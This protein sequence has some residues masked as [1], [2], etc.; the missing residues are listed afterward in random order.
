MYIH[1]DLIAENSNQIA[2]FRKE[3]RALQDQV[4]GLQKQVDVLQHTVAEIQQEPDTA[5]QLVEREK[6]LKDYKAI[7]F[8]LAEQ[9]LTTLRRQASAALSPNGKQYL[10]HDVFGP[11][12]LRELDRPEHPE[13]WTHSTPSAFSDPSSSSAE[14]GAKDRADRILLH[15]IAFMSKQGDRQWVTPPLSIPNIDVALS[16]GKVYAIL[17]HRLH[18]EMSKSKCATRDIHHQ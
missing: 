4:H 9:V 2:Q 11:E 1:T 12:L 7:S 5:Q 6:Q 14:H 17:L 13:I 18:E 3:K 10:S 16:N 15:W 8:Q